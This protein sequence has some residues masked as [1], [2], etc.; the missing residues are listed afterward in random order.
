MKKGKMK[1]LLAVLL[2]L[3]MLMSFAACGGGESEQTKNGESSNSGGN[4]FNDN[5]IDSNISNSKYKIGDYITLGKYEQDNDTSNGKEDI[6]W[7]VIDVKDGKALVI[8]KYQLECKLYNEERINVTWE[9][10]TLR[11]WLNADFINSAFNSTEK[12]KIPTVTVPADKNPSYDTNSGSATQDKI[13]LLSVDEVKRYITSDVERKCGPT[14]YALANGA[15]VNSNNGNCWW[16][17]R[18]TGEYQNYAA[19]VD[20][21]GDVL[22]YGTAVDI[23]D[24]AVRPAMW[25]TIG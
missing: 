4:D 3:V 2:S 15:E 5:G 18:T 14:E 24:I 17:L 16:W 20:T 9:T 23:D 21:V 19:C 13:F 6:E 10:C 25:V 12:A 11:E 8:S 1:K 22:D 7:L